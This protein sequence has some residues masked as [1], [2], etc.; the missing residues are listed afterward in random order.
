MR[1]FGIAA[2]RKLALLGER[3]ID[4]APYVGK[5]REVIPLILQGGSLGKNTLFVVISIVPASESGK[6]GV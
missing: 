3:Q 5:I 1:L 6:I 2:D 4:V